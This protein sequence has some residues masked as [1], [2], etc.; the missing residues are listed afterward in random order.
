M[1][2]IT[3]H[4]FHIKDKNGNN[5][6]M[7]LQN[8]P[9]VFEVNDKFRIF[10]STDEMNHFN[11]TGDEIDVIVRQTSKCMF[12]YDYVYKVYFDVYCEII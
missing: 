1:K 2:T 10:D 8:S 7:E 9:N 4:Y 12:I 3:T 5:F 11:G 6:D